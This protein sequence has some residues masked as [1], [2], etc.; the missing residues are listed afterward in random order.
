LPTKRVKP[1]STLFAGM[2]RRSKIGTA[3]ALRSDPSGHHPLSEH[4]IVWASFDLAAG[5]N[6]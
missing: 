2:P 4:E 1:G 3:Y 5:P 6:Q